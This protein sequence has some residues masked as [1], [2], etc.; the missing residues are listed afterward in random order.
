M[1]L[2][3]DHDAH[4][5]RRLSLREIVRRAERANLT[6][7]RLWQ[8]RSPGG[9]GWH[10]LIS[11]T[12]APATAAEVVALQLLFGSDPLREAYCYNRAR[13]VDR[14]AVPEYWRLQDSWD[15]LYTNGAPW[16]CIDAKLLT[17]HR[18][19]NGKRAPKIARNVKGLDHGK[20]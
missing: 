7:E 15:V 14:R 10:R 4:N 5:S 9:R 18:E 3:L 6:V 20:D 13:M 16:R 8:R 2:K 12:P 17:A 19:R 11:V 1:I